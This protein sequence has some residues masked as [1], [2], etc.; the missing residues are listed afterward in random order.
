MTDKWDGKHDY[1]LGVMRIL[2]L[3]EPLY[4]FAGPG[5]WNDPD[6]LRGRQWR[7]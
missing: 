4:P 1:A 2:D 3:N 6:M 5:H 7:A